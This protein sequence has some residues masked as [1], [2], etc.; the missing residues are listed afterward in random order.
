MGSFRNRLF[1]VIAGVVLAVEA[2]TM[3][4]ALRTLENDALA[5]SSDDLEVGERVFRELLS[6]REQQ[7]ATGVRVLADDF[8]FKEAVATGDADTLQ[9]ALANHGQ[10]IRADLVSFVARDGT[11]S[12]STHRFGG[13]NNDGAFPYADMLDDSRARSTTARTVLLTEG[14]Y[15]LVV[16]PVY[17]PQLIGWV[18]VG[19]EMDDTLAAALKDLTGLEVSFLTF[20]PLVQATVPASTLAP[21]YR[22]TLRERFRTNLPPELAT[23]PTVLDF[24]TRG[25]GFLSYA[26]SITPDSSVVVLLQRSL[27]EA[28]AGYHRLLEQLLFVFLGTLVIALGVARFVAGGITKPV[29]RLAEAARRIAGGSYGEPVDVGRKDELGV[30]ANAFNEMQTGIADRE[31]RILHQSRHDALT[32]L[33]NRVALH[34]R[35]AAALQHSTRHGREGAILLVDLR[36]F[37]AINDTFGHD[38]GDD[39]LRELAKRFVAQSRA[40][41]TVARYGGNCYVVLA[42]EIGASD[43]QSLAQRIIATVK[44]PLS[45]PSAQ[46]RI[47]LTIGAARF[48]NTGVDAE[49]VLRRAEIAMYDA[50]RHGEAL[51]FYREGD[52][53]THLRKLDLMKELAIAIERN[54]LDVVYQPK[55]DLRTNRITD[56]EALVRWQHTRFGFVSPGEFVPIAEQSGLMRQL[57]M[58]VIRKVAAQ[59]HRWAQKGIDIKVS[60]NLS[61]IDLADSA[62]PDRITTI[63]HEHGVPVDRLQLEITES[64]LMTDTD[65]AHGVLERLRAAGFRLSIDDFGTGYSS[66]AQLKH[67]PVSELKI[68]KSF[69]LGLPGNADDA[70]IVRSTIELG[71]NLGLT[72]VAEGAENDQCLAFLREAGCEYGQGYGISRP[73]SAA[74]FET[75]LAKRQPL[76]RPLKADATPE[77]GLLALQP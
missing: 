39:V 76:Q 66:L 36:A 54:E 1:L 8:G 11:I 15:Q 43:L 42:E 30:L 16:A 64:A 70:V 17:A 73:I 4:A 47:D 41:D 23:T 65:S 2:I 48:P 26:V 18:G 37:K 56:A 69:V 34:E 49:G 19:F 71:H 10:R 20:A 50:R 40:S 22:R 27:V 44:D 28:L 12:A 63:L 35:L 58:L 75:F 45:L 25:D 13:G 6:T 60:A 52:D 53:E 29:Q 14:A 38:T 3:V 61:T 55:M 31:Q 59:I 67:M 57:T 74:D 51:G 62:L 72:I 9:S 24:D 46:V 68:D 33:P 77:G 32:D 7:L 5:R 21:Q